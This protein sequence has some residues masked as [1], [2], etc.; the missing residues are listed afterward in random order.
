ME[1]TLSQK[2]RDTFKTK[3]TRKTCLLSLFD[4]LRA[5][6]LTEM[7]D[8]IFHLEGKILYGSGSKYVKLISENTFI[9]SDMW[10]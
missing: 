9:G 4:S 5:A 10:A 1:K 2:S 7:K 6:K 3:S 8:Q